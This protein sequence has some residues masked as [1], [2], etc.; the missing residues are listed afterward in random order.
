MNIFFLHLMIAIVHAM[1]NSSNFE[2]RCGIEIEVE[3]GCL[4]EKTC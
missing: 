3:G 4:D 1:Q 2:R